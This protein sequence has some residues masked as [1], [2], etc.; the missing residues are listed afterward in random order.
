MKRLHPFL[1]LGCCLVTAMSGCKK[2]QASAPLPVDGLKAYAGK[3][4]AK[5]EFDVPADATNGKVFYGTGN[6]VEF[7]VTDA[8]AMQEVMVDGL[9]EDE[10]AIRVVTINADGASSTPRGVMVHVYGDKYQAGLKPRKWLDQVNKDPGSIE[11]A[12]ENALAGEDGVR[13]VYTT[14]TGAKDSAWMEASQ[15]IV[16]IS[17]INTDEPYYY[18]SVFLP[19]AEAIDEFWSAPVDLKTA[20][21]LDFKKEAWVIAGTSGEQAGMEAAKL[22]DNNV[23]S[24]WQSQGGGSYPH[25]V[26]I[27]LGTSKLIDGFYY[28]NYQ[29]PGK[30]AKSVKFELSDDNNAWTTALE[31]QVQDSYLRQRLAVGQTVSG[32][33]LR[34]S[35]VDAY[36]GSATS[37]AQIAEIDAFNTQNAS[38]NNGKD[39]YSSSTAVALVNA[40]APFVGDG[41][42]PFPA[43]GAFRMQKMQGW[44][45]NSAAVVSFD[46]AGKSFSLFTANVWGLSTV[47]NGKV[48]Q[49][50]NL[51]PGIYSLKI[52][53]AH[54]DGP[55]DALGVVAA[56]GTMPDYTV[57]KTSADTWRYYDL[58]ANQNKT[59]ELVFAVAQ[60]SAVNVGIVYNIRDQYAATG[61]PWSSFNLNGME[62][63]KI[64]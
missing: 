7:D 22:I 49:T 46:D 62:L 24:A 27:D 48:Y 26:T 16:A 35:V 3:N 36:D 6:F 55:C 4:R 15:N 58:V 20:V 43:L 44:T 54:A 19:E 40:K 18:Y 52:K 34:V 32:R 45:H 9:A 64:E 13:V 53:V 51:Q 30:S 5:V 56:P 37:T 39:A 59:V 50:V 38:G 60:A 17:N 2:D 10:Q 14:T 63:A 21:M 8:S 47:T 11:L 31:T 23:N 29:G 12:F 61:T 33:Y 28:V 25:W 42:N 1:L 57:L 41:S